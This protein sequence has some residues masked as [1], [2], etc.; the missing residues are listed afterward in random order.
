MKKTLLQS[1]LLTAV[2]ASL[3]YAQEKQVK[4]SVQ[5]STLNEIVLSAVRADEKTPI[6]YAN[7]SKNEI[8]KRNLGQDIPTIMSYMTSVVTTT[9]AGNGIGYS[10]F[11]VRGSD[12]T[13]VNVTLNGIPYNDGESQGS[14]WVNMP[15]FTSSVQNLQLQRGVGT[16]TNGSAAFGASLNLKTDDFSH[17]ANGE[18]SNSFGSYNTRK[19]TVKF[20]TG[21]I[22]DKFEIAG[23]LSDMRSDGY[24]DRASS[25]MKSYYLQGVY[26]GETSLVKAVVFGGKQKT[27]QAWNGVSQADIDKYG[28]R[29][30]PAG[31][32][33]DD[34]GNTQFYDNE[35]DNYIQTHYQ[36]HWSEK[37]S[38]AW[39]S[40]V[41]LHYTK[42]DGYY[43]NYKT[44]QKFKT[45]GFQ[46]IIV[47]GKE[48]NKTDLI[49]QKSLANHFY[50]MV[51]NTNYTTDKLNIILG[52]GANKYEGDHFGNV[53]WTREPVKIAPNYEYYRDDAV[54]TD[55]NFYAKATWQF[56]DQW[57][58][59]GDMQY[60]RVT[61]EANGIETGLVDDKFNF[62]NPKGGITYQLN[63]SNQ[64]YFSYAKGNREPNRKD[65]EGEGKPKSESMDDYELGWRFKG[66]RATVNVNAYYMKYRNQLILTGEIN[67]VGAMLR[68]NSGDSYRAGI[69]ID[70]N[71]RILDKL[72]WAPSMT[73]SA[74][75]NKNFMTT[76]ADLP[77]NLGTTNI[78][79]SPDFIASNAITYLPV[80]GMSVSL[81]TKFV[82][83]QYMAN[84][85][86][87]ESKLDSYFINDLSAT[88]EFPIKG[89][90]RSV[91]VSVLA[92]NIFN[93]KYMSNG[94]YDPEWGP[95][96]YPQAE[97]NILAGLTIK[98]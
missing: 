18:I 94:Y 96:Y 69:E 19:S 61:Y 53:L 38:P 37:W 91:G 47:D 10:S 68:A 9:D 83:E 7:L 27:Y 43:E 70:A 76:V 30:N 64:L 31:K 22:N 79:F 97:F 16:S 88:Y 46:P 65:Y 80:E 59:Y 67:D 98:F 78:A 29:Y 17:E 81:L 23:R 62:F 63:N 25:R 57:S 51:F 49:R 21:L 93:V 8:G 48:V 55:L 58:L 74:N 6:A 52:G 1:L 72:Y 45:Y 11:R 44:N 54:K 66:D 86:A 15:D 13:R 85:D 77:V 26:V 20:S 2:C 36:L 95:A 4:D 89:W 3:T 35:T 42:G 60:R 71:V 87:K 84:L 82:G 14:F 40:N 33:K 75:K 39:S 12:A 73:I 32:Y 90:V 41:S 56:A 5:Q 50:G 24:I 34:Q 28:R 92:N